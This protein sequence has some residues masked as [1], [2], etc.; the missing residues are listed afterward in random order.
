MLLNKYKKNTNNNLNNE[1]LIKNGRNEIKILV[2]LNEKEGNEKIPKLDNFCE[3]NNDIWFSFEKGGKSLSTLTF[4]IK[5]E[6]I[7]NERI[8]YIQKG[9]FLKNLFLKIKEFK[10]LS[11]IFLEGINYINKKGII[12]SDINPENILIE[13]EN[14]NNTFHIKK[15]KNNR[16]WKFILF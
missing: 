2:K 1:D 5:G 3:D 10:L 6:F 16:L 15:Y 4:K 13:Y 7:N 8:Y 14:T 9:I 11:K 12:H